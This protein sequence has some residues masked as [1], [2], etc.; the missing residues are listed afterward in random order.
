MA[1]VIRSILL[2]AMLLSA[3]IAQGPVDTNSILRR[4]E[5][6]YNETKTMQA[7]FTQTLKEKGRTHIPKRGVVY[8]N[9]KNHQ[10]RWD[11]TEPAG[12]FFLSSDK[13]AWDYDKDKK[14][15]ERIPMKETDDL[16]IPLAF[17]LGTIDFDKDFQKFEQTSDREIAV[18]KA[19][20]KSDKL[21]FKDLTM[22]IAP[23]ASIRQVTVLGQDGSTMLYVLEKEQRNLPL[24]DALF[25]FTLPQGA[26]LVDVRQ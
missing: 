11:Y 19:H 5:K 4:V 2:V 13:Y 7:N 8:L 3:L 14:V 17:L 1:T 23:D 16:R 20:P 6:R 9:K 24:S 26:Q 22:W 12:D 21:L 10:A 25:R 15:V 18:I